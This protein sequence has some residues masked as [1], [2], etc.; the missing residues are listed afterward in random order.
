MRIHRNTYYTP[1][2]LIHKSLINASN[3]TFLSPPLAAYLDGSVISTWTESQSYVVRRQE[4]LV[5][6]G[7]MRKGRIPGIKLLLL[8]DKVFFA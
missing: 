3:K 5:M 2:A 1:G 4:S 7:T 6:I 8:Q